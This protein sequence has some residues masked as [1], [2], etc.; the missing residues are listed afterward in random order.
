MSLELSSVILTDLLF[1]ELNRRNVL[2][3]EKLK[4][5]YIKYGLRAVI[6]DV[7]I[8]WLVF[9]GTKWYFPKLKGLRLLLAILAVQIVHDLVF[10]K[11]FS[12][13]ERGESESM[14]FFQDYA[15]EIK[16]KAI[17]GDSM[18]MVSSFVMFYFF[19]DYL[20]I[21]TTPKKMLLLALSMYI[22]PYVLIG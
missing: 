15:E 10:Y 4:Q 3:S 1:I 19:K 21:H 13:F 20:K 6:A 22:V 2:Q 11:I 18:M 9:Y 14:D 12:S 5:W 16:E 8:I 17:I 7:A